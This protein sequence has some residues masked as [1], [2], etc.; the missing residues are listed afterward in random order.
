MFNLA[1]VSSS[2]LPDSKCYLCDSTYSLDRQFYINLEDLCFTW[3]D[4][5]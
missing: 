3:S 2:L 1:I 4:D 5:C